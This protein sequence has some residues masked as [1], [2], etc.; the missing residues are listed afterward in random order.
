MLM[1]FKVENLFE[2]RYV[3]DSRFDCIYVIEAFNRL[4]IY[5]FMKLVILRDC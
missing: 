2:L 1:L 4:L 5:A 3:Q